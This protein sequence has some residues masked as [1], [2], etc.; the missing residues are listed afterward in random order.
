M[1]PKTLIKNDIDQLLLA[2]LG[3]YELVDMWWYSSNKAFDNQT[4]EEVYQSG[5]EGRWKVYNYVVHYA[6]I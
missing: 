6:L 5:E 3:R 2:M 1:Q 4:P